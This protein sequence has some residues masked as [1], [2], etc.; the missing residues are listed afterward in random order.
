MS[1]RGRVEEKLKAIGAVLKRNRK[2]EVWELPNGQNFVRSSTPSDVRSEQNDMSELRRLAGEADPH[3]GATGMRRERRN[4]PGRMDTSSTV[5][6]APVS[7]FAAKLSMSG[8]VEA[9]LRGEVEA[10]KAKLSEAESRVCG[11]WWCRLV[12]R[13]E[14]CLPE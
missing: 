14:R 9:A 8:A 10:L 13:A 4:K 1:A 5:H 3:K 2:H 11:C 7:D 12:R 6:A